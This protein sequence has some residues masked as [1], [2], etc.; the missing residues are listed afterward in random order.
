MLFPVSAATQNRQGHATRALLMST[1]ERLFADQG[2]DAVS[3]RAVNATAGL[4]AAS[5]HYHFGSKDELLRAVIMDL[6]TAVGLAT[7]ANIDALAADPIAPTPDALVRAVTAPYL[8]LLRRHPI[9]GMRWIKIVAQTAQAGPADDTIEP[10]LRES[11]LPQV[12][13]AFPNADPARWE[14]RWAMSI[15]GFV[16]GMSRADEWPGVLASM[17]TLGAF[18]E[19]MVTFVVGGAERLINS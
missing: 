3:V 5:V 10:Y 11:L 17:E 1:A 14:G 19:D 18:Y 16:Q 9:R 6:G 15:M 4:G 7:Q 12:R 13:R 2:V 8:E